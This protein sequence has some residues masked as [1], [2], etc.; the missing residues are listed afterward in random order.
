V[1]YVM[2]VFEVR[3]SVAVKISTHLPS[4]KL[5]SS[6]CSDLSGIV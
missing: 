6:S 5:L 4:P 2:F 1:C 3:N